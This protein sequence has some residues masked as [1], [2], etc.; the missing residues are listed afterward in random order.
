VV[1]II[2]GFLIYSHSSKNSPVSKGTQAL[3]IE[4]K[5]L[6]EFNAEKTTQSIPL[7]LKIKIGGRNDA[8]F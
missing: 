4:N 7:P 2:A 1:L 5:G 6:A 3:A 8:D